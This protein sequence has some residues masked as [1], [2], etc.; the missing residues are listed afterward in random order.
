[1]A[2]NKV[3]RLALFAAIPIAG[4][5]AS[6]SASAD[7]I[8]LAVANS[9]CTAMKRLG[10]LYERQ[11][12]HRL[13]FQCK[14]SGLLAKG[15]KGGAISADVYV[16]AS[17]K[18]MDFLVDAGMVR[19]ADVTSP[20]GNQLVVAAAKDS[21]IELGAWSDLAT[22][23]VKTVLIGD[24]SIAPF[25]RHAK[26][27]LDHTALWERVKAKVTTKKH[28][29][30]LADTLAVADGQTVGILFSTNTTAKH[31]VLL[32]VDGA[33]H[34]PIRYYAAP[35]VRSANRPIVAGFLAFMQGVEAQEVFKAEG[36]RV[37]APKGPD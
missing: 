12:G 34:A 37:Y 9:T 13:D 24:P 26:Q 29:T 20:W 31:R 30:L 32:E 15:L 7:A 11:S 33:W 23:K 16:S 1:M 36:F 21:Q 14:A 6:F 25:G 4:L 35:L 8:S 17:G 2:M 10:A 28:I 19:A 27:A 22:D 3:L 18:W 5:L